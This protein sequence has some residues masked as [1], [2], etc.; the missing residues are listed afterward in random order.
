FRGQRRE[1]RRAGSQPEESGHGIGGGGP[2]AAR[3]GDRQRHRRHA[4]RPH[5]PAAAG[6]QEPQPSGS[7]E[8]PVHRTDRRPDR[9]G[10]GG[11]GG[12]GEGGKIAAM[13]RMVLPAPTRTQGDG[14]PARLTALLDVSIEILLALLLLALPAMYGTVDAWSEMIATTLGGAIAACVAVRI[15]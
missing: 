4:C 14:L 2:E 13:T 10:G 8:R 7:R 6:P 11:G 9:R 1:A 3:P 15:V 12:G 5:R